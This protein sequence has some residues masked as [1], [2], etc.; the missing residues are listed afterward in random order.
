MTL[1]TGGTPLADDPEAVVQR[2]LDAFNA[3]DVD[4]LLAVYAADAQVFEHPAKLLATGAAALRERFTLR[5]REP[6]LHAA[7][8]RRIVMGSF[9]VDH[10]TVTRTFP[11]GPGTIALV[12]IYEVRGG[13]IARSWM[14]AGPQTLAVERL[15]P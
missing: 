8:Q 7:L 1:A 11:E 2:Q 6:N 12:M 9:V 3:R 4:A 13:R 10:E 14:I 15:Q 5:F